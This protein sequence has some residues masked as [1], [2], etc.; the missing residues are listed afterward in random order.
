MRLR[1]LVIILLI[2]GSTGASAQTGG[3]ARVKLA[4]QLLDLT[5]AKGTMDRALTATVNAQLATMSANARRSGAPESVLNKIPPLQ[6]ELRALIVAE[7]EWEVV[8]RD[9]AAIHASVFSEKELRSIIAFYRSPAGRAMVAK[10]PEISARMLEI[11][12]TRLGLLEP[13][14][15]ELLKKRLQQ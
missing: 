3:E 11:T 13:K 9:A 8:A 15:Q 6:D 7:V 12:R 2:A 4:L 5:D 14:I 1:N 10:T